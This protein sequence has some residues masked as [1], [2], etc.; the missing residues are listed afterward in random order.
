MDTLVDLSF[1]DFKE[2]MYSVDMFLKNSDIRTRYLDS[3][4][5]K[6]FKKSLMGATATKVTQIGVNPYMSVEEKNV[7]RLII[8]RID[9][10]KRGIIKFFQNLVQH[11]D[12]SGSSPDGIRTNFISINYDF[13]VEAIYDSFLTEDSFSLYFYR[14]ITPNEYKHIRG[15]PKIQDDWLIMNYFKLNGGMEIYLADENYIFDYTAK[16]KE[17]YLQRSPLL[18]LPSYEQDYSEL[19]FKE[20]FQKST[21]LLS[22]S[23]VLIIVG[24]SLPNEDALIRFLLKHFSLDFSDG[25]SKTIFYISLENHTVLLEKIQS[26]FKMV[27][28]NLTIYTYCGT[29]SQWTTE[30]N[31]LH[32]INFPE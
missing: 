20:I 13:I 7:G 16:S 18:I 22:Q 31:L 12:G 8:P 10:S 25:H 32:D 11:I 4:N 6:L 9:D 26:V 5:L 3:R 2:V 24:Y 23:K 15:L 30:V 21:R 29:F 14:G 27:T 19:Y 1:N 28:N 17:N